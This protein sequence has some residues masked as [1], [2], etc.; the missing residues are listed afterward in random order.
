MVDVCGD[1]DDDVVASMN[2][3]LI[4]MKRD[5][6]VEKMRRIN[7]RSCPYQRRMLGAVMSI[8]ERPSPKE[9]VL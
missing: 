7:P 5:G 1:D 6:E 8:G 3:A 2:C 9:G 4:E